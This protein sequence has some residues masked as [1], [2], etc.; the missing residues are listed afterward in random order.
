[1]EHKDSHGGFYP[2]AYIA[3]MQM[4]FLMQSN[5][6]IQK[7]KVKSNKKYASANPGNGIFNGPRL[8]SSD[9]EFLYMGVVFHGLPDKAKMEQL[10]VATWPPETF[11]IDNDFMNRILEVQKNSVYILGSPHLPT[12]LINEHPTPAQNNVRL[13]SNPYIGLLHLDTEVLPYTELTVH[14]GNLIGNPFGVE[15]DD[16]TDMSR[17][18]RDR[19]APRRFAPTENVKYTKR[20]SQEKE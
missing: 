7:S 11:G 19:N 20:S 15:V 18:K 4:A 16:T 17:L 1:M 10:I 5:I 8:M 6:T 2:P 13:V 9:T 12:S 3:S 14:Y